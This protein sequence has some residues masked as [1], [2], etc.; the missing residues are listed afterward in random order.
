MS[1]FNPFCKC[2]NPQRIVNPYTNEAMTVPCGHCKACILAKNSRYAFQCDLESYSS[3][4]TL[5]I[6]LTYANRFI[7]RAQFVDSMER[8]Y[9]HDLVDVETGEY[10][11]D[12]DLPIKE[13]ER[14][15]DKFHLFG[16]LPYL[17]KFDLQLF[18]K[19]FR[20]YVAKRFPKEKVRYFAIG[21]YGPVHF[22]PHYHVLLFLQSDEALQVCST[23]LSEAWSYGRVDCQLYKGKC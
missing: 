8:P 15:Q 10:L 23:A 1:L 22:R 11:G 5:F 14:L 6:T 13:I 17:R 2:L 21:E 16:Y 18:F 20:Y 12:A 3:K 7:P 9:G 4:H 19:R